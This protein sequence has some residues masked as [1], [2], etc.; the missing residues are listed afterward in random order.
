MYP[1]RTAH[2]VQTDQPLPRPQGAFTNWKGTAI[3]LVVYSVFPF[4]LIWLSHRRRWGSRYSSHDLIEDA[5]AAIATGLIV[6]G[7]QALDRGGHQGVSRI[8]T[9]CF[10]IWFAIFII[11]LLGT[12][13]LCKATGLDQAEH[14]FFCLSLLP[15]AIPLPLALYLNRKQP[16]STPQPTS[17]NVS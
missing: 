9:K 8:V 12:T 14:Y 7:F 13:T 11:S 3:T 5:L 17:A 6:A 10:I 15:A 4:A 16:E 1:D 2:V